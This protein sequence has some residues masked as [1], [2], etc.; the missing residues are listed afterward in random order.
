MTKDHIYAS[1]KFTMWRVSVYDRSGRVLPD[2]ANGPKL[3]PHKLNKLSLIKI[4][5]D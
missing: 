3:Q 2:V 5:F 1:A 4:K